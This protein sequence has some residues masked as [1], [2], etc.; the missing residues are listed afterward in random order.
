M[1][2][3]YNYTSGDYPSQFLRNRWFP[4]LDRLRGGKY[5]GEGTKESPYNPLFGFRPGILGSYR[6]IERTDGTFSYQYTPSEAGNYLGS[7][8]GSLSGDERL[9]LQEYLNPSYGL[10][11]NFR[12]SRSPVRSAARN[13]P[14][15]RGRGYKTRLTAQQL[16]DLRRRAIMSGMGET[17]M[18]ALQAEQ[19]AEERR[20][21]SSDIQRGYRSRY[22]SSVV[23]P[24][25]D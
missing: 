23:Y 19:L 14:V 18:R 6:P 1:N 25:R 16:E 10:T 3:T 5:S 7:V 21:L 4:D 13:E 24:E 8:W 11:P 15:V 2:Q 20:A 17:F 12:P 22:I 9:A